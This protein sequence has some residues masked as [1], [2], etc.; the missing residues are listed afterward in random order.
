MMNEESLGLLVWKVEEGPIA[1]ED[2]PDEDQIGTEGFDWFLE[3]LV[4]P[5]DESSVYDYTTLYF[6]TLDE[7]YNFKARVDKAMEPLEMII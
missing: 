3:V 2:L 5:I 1:I 7:C 6:T 4:S